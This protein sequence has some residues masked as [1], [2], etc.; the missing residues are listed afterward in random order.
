[1]GRLGKKQ[2]NYS[3][4]DW[5]DITFPD[6]WKC[7]LEEDI[8]TLVAGRGSK[9]II[10]ISYFK[11]TDTEEDFSKVALAHLN[12]FLNQYD[13]I[14]KERPKIMKEE[15]QSVAK[16]LGEDDGQFVEVWTFISKGTVLV[17]TYVSA[18][19]TKE[20]SVAEK[21]ISSIMLQN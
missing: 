12:R 5:F 1:M 7:K 18:S 19:I 9:G 15:N 21:I 6:S 10:Q 14:S 3:V 4:E 2:I 11:R 16:V 8:F 20:A 13:I 17:A